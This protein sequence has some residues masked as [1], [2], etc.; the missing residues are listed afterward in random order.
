MEVVCID[1]VNFSDLSSGSRASGSNEGT[2][3]IFN[4]ETN[5]RDNNNNNNHCKKNK[6]VMAS[7]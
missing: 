4:N 3:N 7:S 1:T 6:I 5:N 2:M